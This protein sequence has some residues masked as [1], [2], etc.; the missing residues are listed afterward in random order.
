MWGHQ[1]V[2]NDKAAQADKK[3]IVL[4]WE[5]VSVSREHPSSRYHSMPERAT[6]KKRSILRM[7]GI[8]FPS[9]QM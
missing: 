4:G 6:V 3:D 7:L 9:K 2:D 8:P 5:M 1:Q